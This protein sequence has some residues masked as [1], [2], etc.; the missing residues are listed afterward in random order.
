[1]S[2]VYYITVSEDEDG[3]RLD[4]FLQK[5]LKGTPIG[6]LQKL[7]RKGQI[8]VDSKRVK[9]N[10]RISEGQSV[11]I[12]PLEKKENAKNKISEQDAEFIRSL[13]IYDKDGVVA[14]NKPSG[15]ATQGGTNINRHIDGLLPAL[16]NKEGVVP[17][18]V[19]RLDKDTSGVLLLARSAEMARE[20]GKVFQGRN[21]RKIYWALTVPAPEMNSGE[22]RAPIKKVGGMGNEKMAVD[23]EG[24]SAV[25]LFDIVDRAHKQ[26]A[27][28]AFWPRTGRTHQ[29]RVHAAHLGCPI[30][31]DGKY[32]GHEAML[33]GVDHV[34]R[35]HLHARSLHFI[36]PK[37]NKPIDVDAPLAGDIE[38][39]W[40]DLGFDP[41]S[42]AQVFADIKDI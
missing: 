11:R 18:L 2:G 3:Q 41:N 39:S 13:V 22:I 35:V 1:M 32:G 14:I 25:T 5:H 9:T 36:H 27:F 15:I 7:M 20:L 8:R 29:I 23:T 37:T 28:V 33:E 16:A 10:T 42:K 38:K 30:L 26:L 24:Q 4:R 19:H 40:K 31:G 21:I 12:P 34:K 17:R 6:L